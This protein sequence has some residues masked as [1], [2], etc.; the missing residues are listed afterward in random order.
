[1]RQLDSKEQLST[2][3]C[4]TTSEREFVY[5]ISTATLEGKVKSC[6]PSSLGVALMWH[7]FLCQVGKYVY[8][9]YVGTDHVE[10]PIRD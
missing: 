9:W 4:P 7:M 10:H 2:T 8:T 6:L 1:M 3:C 5:S